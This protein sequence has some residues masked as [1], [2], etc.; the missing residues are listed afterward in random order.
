MRGC[1]VPKI[2]SRARGSVGG[3]W[4]LTPASLAGAGH[5]KAAQTRKDPRQERRATVPGV[6]QVCA[7]RKVSPAFRPGAALPYTQAVTPFRSAFLPPATVVLSLPPL[8]AP[9]PRFP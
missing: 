2:T 6:D 3:S 8:T 5:P 7:D 1:C 4:S 9:L